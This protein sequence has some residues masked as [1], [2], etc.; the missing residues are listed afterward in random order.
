MAAVG[1]SVESISIAGREFAVAADADINRKIGGTE[2]EVQANGNQ[3]ARIIKT[4]VPS[5]FTGIVVEIDDARGDHEYLQNKADLDLFF[6]VAVTYA[7]GAVYQGNAMIS[8]ELQYSS[9]NATA[10]FDLMG[11]GKFTKQ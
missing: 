7:S 2:N 10:S 3:T 1:G 5:A 6:P 11:D 8:G 4:A 9:Q